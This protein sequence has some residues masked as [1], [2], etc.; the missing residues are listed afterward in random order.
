MRGLA[1]VNIRQIRKLPRQRIPAFGKIDEAVLK[2]VQSR[3][4]RGIRVKGKF[5]C[6]EA[7]RV[8]DA[9]LNGLETVEEK[10][11]YATF[12]A[13]NMWLSRFSP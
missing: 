11:L 9:M 7:K 1:K 6:V 5:I 2:W 10:A 4:E 3:N 13:S 8:R 12:K